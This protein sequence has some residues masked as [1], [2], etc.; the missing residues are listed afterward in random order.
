MLISPDL[1]LTAA[2]NIYNKEE[3]IFFYNFKFYPGEMGLLVSPYEV[4][5]YFLPKEY[6][7]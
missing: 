3:K 7:E 4:E 5:K 2:H 1:V 6:I